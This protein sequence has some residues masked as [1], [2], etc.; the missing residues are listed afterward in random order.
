MVGNKKTRPLNTNAKPKTIRETPKA[1]ISIVLK[2]P[3]QAWPPD[4]ASQVGARE[5]VFGNVSWWPVRVAN[6]CLRVIGNRSAQVIAFTR[7][8][9]GTYWRHKPGR[10]FRTD[11]PVRLEVPAPLTLSE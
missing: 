8:Q 9:A 10:R 2:Y 6:E 1:P 4:A 7:T 5:E 11:M 3:S